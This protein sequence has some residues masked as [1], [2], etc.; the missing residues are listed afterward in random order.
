MRR[1]LNILLITNHRRFKIHFRALPWAK[2]LAERGHFIDVM[3]H[4]DHERWRT[5][6]EESDGVRIVQ[7]PD[8]LVGALRQGWDP[9]CA[10]RRA[11]LLFRENRPYDIIHCLDTRPAVV[12]PA[13]AYARFK[14]IP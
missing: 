14:R 2:S 9:V 5:A 3:C 7:N 12:L 4:A 8:L 1:P 13:L 6:Y 11:G 10:I